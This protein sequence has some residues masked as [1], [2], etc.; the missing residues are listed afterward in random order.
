MEHRRATLK[1][2]AGWVGHLARPRPGPLPLAR[3]VRSALAVTAP[4][5]LG[6]LLGHAPQG[7]LAAMGALPSATG[8]RGGAYRLRI[9]RVGWSVFAAAVGF[10]IGGAVQGS[11]LSTVLAVGA[12]AAFS[13]AVSALGATASSASLQLLVFTII[14]AGRAFPPPLWMPPVLV[15]AGGAWALVL[16]TIWW[17]VRREA[18]ERDAVAAVYAAVANELEAVGSPGVEAARRELTRVLNAAYDTLTL[19]RLRSGGPEL[20]LRR[21]VVALN[22]AVPLAEATTVLV[23]AGQRPPEELITR[24]RRIAH[25][26]SSGETV[27][28]E[29]VPSEDPLPAGDPSAAA[30]EAAIRSAATALVDTS[31]LRDGAGTDTRQH[32]AGGRATLVAARRRLA[33]PSRTAQLATLRLTACIVLAEILSEVFSLQ[34]SYWVALTVAIV[35][36]PDFGSVFARAVQRAI[37]TAIGVV[38]GAAVLTLVPGGAALLPF[39]AVFAA[40][41]PI[42]IDRNYGLFSIFMTP[43]ILILI[44]SLSGNP[45]E[46]VRARLL[47]TLLGCAIVLVLGYAIWPETWRTRLPER[48][49][50]AIDDV[51]VYLDAVVSDRADRSGQPRRLYRLLSDLRTGFEQTLAEPPPASTVAAAWWPAVIALE[52][53]LDATTALG[54]SLLHGT[55]RPSQQDATLLRSA[56][57]ELSASARERRAPANL[58]LPDD[59]ALSDLADELRVARGV[60]ESALR[61][62]SRIAG[63]GGALAQ[64]AREPI[65]RVFG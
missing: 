24:V 35:M 54:T 41:L 62:Q 12:V 64:R 6:L 33:S 15:L 57:A 22:E 43:L 29:D 60:F 2:V 52:R 4:F 19:T 47:D 48:F 42:G 44:D 25:A 14:A 65:G 27:A 58:P 55:P 1:R 18:P 37:G 51:A 17:A 5:G 20:R 40:M 31:A 23:R 30:L 11:G 21:L 7:L 28:P 38:I 36:K 61:E 56:V 39:L 46:L 50:A 34:R 45:A 8:D 26:I 59:P 16:I 3:A 13:G 63:P 9:V 10:L 32:P 49:A 53:V